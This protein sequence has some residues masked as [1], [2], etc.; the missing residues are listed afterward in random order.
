MSQ[1]LKKKEL[2]PQESPKKGQAPK[3]SDEALRFG[4]GK[5]W[6]RFLGTLNDK[7]IETAVDSLREYLGIDSLKSKSFVD[8]GCGSGLFSLSARK[9]GAKVHSFDYDENSVGCAQELYR[10][11]YEGDK[12]WTI[13]QGSALDKDY[14]SQLGQFDVVYSWGVLHHTGD[15]YSALDNAALLVKRG[16]ALFISIYNDQGRMSR[17]WTRFKKVYNFVP[18]PLKFLMSVS[19]IPTLWGPRM[20]KD[21]L[22]SLNPLKT[23]RAYSRN[24]GMSAWH[25]IVDWAGGYPF[26]VAKPEEIFEFFQKRGF[27]LTRL[28]TCAGGLGCNQFVFKK[29]S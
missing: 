28:Q 16:G 4:F 12:N 19:L 2:S 14:I 23:W 6:G 22:S 26:E 21:T 24:R 10:R 8:I 11:Y 20:L 15:M 17:V 13:E 7:R 27:E 18:K 1:V 9:L 5:N 3:P 25:D 29:V